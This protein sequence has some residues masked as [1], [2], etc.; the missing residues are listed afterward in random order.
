MRSL[1]WDFDGVIIDSIDECL[2]TSYNAYLQYQ[3]I[4]NE[5]IETLE[6]IPKYYREEFYRTRKYVRPAGE[7]FAL[8]KA[9]SDNIK[10]ESYGIFRK[11]LED[12]SE[13]I[14]EF[15]RLFYSTRDK[16][17]NKYPQYWFELH[18]S[19]PQI[20]TNWQKLKEHFDF[21]IVSN[22]DFRSISEILDHFGLAINKNNI[23]GTDF[24]LNKKKIVEHIMSTKSTAANRVFLIDDNY[25]NLLDFCDT[26]I[27][28]FFASWGYGEMPEN[29]NENITPVDLDNFNACLLRVL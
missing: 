1:L 9:A 2:L 29:S 19:Y 12:N 24:S 16:L 28:L 5:F 7:F 23:F 22:K 27:K 18:R 26:G 6:D 25:Q 4:Y 8:Y 3:G 13:D 15:Q 14:A 17:K 10:I 20:K 11:L 21:Y